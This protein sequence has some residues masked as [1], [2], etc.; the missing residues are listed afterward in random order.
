MYLYRGI[1][2]AGDTVG[3]FFSE[4]RDLFAAKRFIRKALKH[5]GRPKR[6]IIDGSQT[7]RLTCCGFSDTRLS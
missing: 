4:H 6:Y 1:E 5:Y 2:S 7:N 3:F